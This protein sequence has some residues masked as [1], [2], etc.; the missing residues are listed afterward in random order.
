MVRKYYAYSSTSNKYTG[1]TRR[2]DTY[3]WREYMCTK[4]GTRVPTTNRASLQ[5]SPPQSDS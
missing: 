3:E 1:L 4:V 2:V 5:P